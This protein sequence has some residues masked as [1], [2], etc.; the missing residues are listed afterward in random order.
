METRW[1]QR[2]LGPSQA[3]ANAHLRQVGAGGAQLGPERIHFELAELLAALKGHRGA[4]PGRLAG[5]EAGRDLLGRVVGTVIHL[6]AAPCDGKV[7]SLPRE[8]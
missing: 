5:R 2:L 8:K 4:D 6:D 1:L 7:R 3:T